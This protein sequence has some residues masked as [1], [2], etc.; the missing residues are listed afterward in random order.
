MLT[1]PQL[2]T[3]AATMTASRGL[4]GD[5]VFISILFEHYKQLETLR[6]FSRN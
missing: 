6:N 3:V 1:I 4:L 5:I 2:Y